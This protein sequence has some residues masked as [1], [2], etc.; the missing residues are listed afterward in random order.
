MNAESSPIRFHR[1]VSEVCTPPYYECLIHIVCRGGSFSFTL[2]GTRYNVAPG[3]YTI[4]PNPVL[5]SDVA[6]AADFAGYVFTFPWTFAMRLVATNN[7]SVMGQLSLL[8]N[9]VLP[10]DDASMARCCQLLDILQQ[11]SGLSGHLFGTE[12]M[13]SLLS[14]HIL[15]IYD[16]HARKIHTQ[17]LSPTITAQVRQF[18]S[19]LADG[20]Y[21]VSRSPA[22]FADRLCITPHYLTDICR[23]ISGKPATYWI[24][25]FTV[26]EITRLVADRSLSL[27][28][29]SDRMHFASLSY[30]SRY[31]LKHL[32]LTPS[33]LRQQIN[34]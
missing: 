19:L 25:R 23:K 13:S 24:D 7:F 1:T 10:L 34:G 33:Q 15:D 2:G 31:V 6:E 18:I 28:D 26:N 21:L 11:R 8:L 9:P 17:E 3:S 30:F 14:A 29:V 32:G 12:M 27:S 22:H 16:I 5:V 20:E 4:F